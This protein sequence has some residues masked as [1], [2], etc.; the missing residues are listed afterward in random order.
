MK[1]KPFNYEISFD[2]EFII[3]SLDQKT[4]G[5]LLKASPPFKLCIEYN[6]YIK[7]L[8]CHKNS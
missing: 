3:E 5:L 6:I 1:V 2:A 8:V 4:I 7:F